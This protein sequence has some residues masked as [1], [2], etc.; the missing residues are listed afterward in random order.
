[1]TLILSDAQILAPNALRQALADAGVPAKV[2]RD[3]VCY[4]PVPE[5]AA[6]LQAVAFHQ[7]APAR[8]PRR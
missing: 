1:V 5:R 2:T 3:S 8:R 7:P 4:N 6:P